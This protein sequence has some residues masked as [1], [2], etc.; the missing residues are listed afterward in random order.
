MGKILVL[1]IPAL[2]V[3]SNPA[4]F[5]TVPAEKPTYDGRF[6]LP[7]DFTHAVFGDGGGL[8]EFGQWMTG[9]I[10]YHLDLA[11]AGY[12]GRVVAVFVV[13]ENGNTDQ[14]EIIY[15]IHD[16]L[17]EE[18]VRVIRMS[19]GMWAPGTNDKGEPIRI[20]YLIPV[21]FKTQ[22]FIF[23]LTNPRM[24]EKV[25]TCPFYRIPFPGIFLCRTCPA[26]ADNLCP[27]G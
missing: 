7:E 25:S 23:Q 20:K 14:V 6:P 27:R 26:A 19:S 12:T 15:T 21:L 11:E 13:D 9:N 2:F 10:R 17:S 5:A 1:F 16:K 22:Q 8:L 18:V 24:Y 3:I 4:I